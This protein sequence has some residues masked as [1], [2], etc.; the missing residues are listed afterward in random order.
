[1]ELR[2]WLDS[3]GSDALEAF[4]AEAEKTRGEDE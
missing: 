3:F 4:K 1:M 2:D